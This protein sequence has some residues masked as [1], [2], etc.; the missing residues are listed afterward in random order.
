M[1][2]SLWTSATDQGHEGKWQWVYTNASLDCENSFCDWHA[3]EPSGGET[4][5]C[6][7][8]WNDYYWSNGAW[9]D[10]SCNETL[11]HYVCEKAATTDSKKKVWIGLNDLENTGTVT[12]TNQD[13]VTFTK[14]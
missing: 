8:I 13:P 1:G 5:N 7:E 10:A 6:L 14:W 9:N 2:T 3:G 12:W 4:E 11:T